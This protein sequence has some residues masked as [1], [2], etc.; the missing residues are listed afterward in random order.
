MP[1]S[2]SWRAAYVTYLVDVLK[3]YIDVLKYYIDQ[4]M[5]MVDH[6][7]PLPCQHRAVCCAAAANGVFPP[8]MSRFHRCRRN[9]T[10]L[11]NAL[12]LPP[13]LHF[14]QAGRH[15]RH[16]AFTKLPLRMPLLRCR[17][18]QCRVLTKLLPLPPSW[19][20]PPCCCH[21]SADTITTSVVFVSIVIVVT[22][23]VAVFITIA[24][25]AFSLLL[26]IFCALAIAVAA[27]VFIATAVVRGGSTAVAVAAAAMPDTIVLPTHC[28]PLPLH[29]RQ[30][31][32]AAAATAA[33]KLPTRFLPR[34]CC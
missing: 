12:P 2:Y 23:I 18:R 15:R 33:A 20:L 17:C 7:P 32:A 27:G 21:A 5:T 3:Y 16:N 9:A 19:L 25:S 24:F 14:R 29:C 31:A 6:I 8:P 26:I 4:Y 1:L 13:K 28:P 11:P 30:A 22:V 34:C 10:A